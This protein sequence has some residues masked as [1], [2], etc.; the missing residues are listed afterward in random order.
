MSLTSALA[1]ISSW[2]ISR[3]P[4]CAAVMSAVHPSY[5]AALTSALA[6]ISSL[7]TSRFP[8]CTAIMNAVFPLLFIDLGIGFLRS[9]DAPYQLR[10][11]R[12]VWPASILT[13]GSAPWLS[14]AFTLASS[15]RSTASQSALVFFSCCPDIHAVIMK[16]T[17]AAQNNL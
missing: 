13:L 8:S 9:P 10:Y 16:R 5:S 12:I 14:S 1:L 15:L 4:F 2:A 17:S 3:C 6:L 7:T 11:L